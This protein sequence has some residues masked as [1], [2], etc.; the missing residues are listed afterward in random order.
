MLNRSLVIPAFLFLF[1]LKIYPQKLTFNA[2]VGYSHR[3]AITPDSISSS[4]AHHK[5]QLLKGSNYNFELNFYQEGYGLGFKVCSFSSSI[6]SDSVKI[7]DF[8]TGKLSDKILMNY[9]ALQYTRLSQFKD[10][11]FYYGY[12]GGIGLLYYY[13]DN[14]SIEEK[15]KIKGKTW[16]VHG[17]IGIDYLLLKNVA[18]GVNINA[19]LA[20][21]NELNKNGYTEKLNQKENILRFDFNAGIR[22]YL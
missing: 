15:N 17:S 2:D 16:G 22:I 5:K 12:K 8:G 14:I 18:F 19:I 7:N 9:Y 21:L 1:S 4:Y 10:T 13:N 3:F 11:H 6:S 20:V